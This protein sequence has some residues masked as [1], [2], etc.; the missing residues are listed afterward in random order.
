VLYDGDAAGIKAALRGIDLL[1]ED[2]MNVKVLLL[3]DGEDPDSFARSHNATEFAEYIEKYETD[4]IRFKTKL[5]LGETKDPFK[6]AEVISDII[7]TISLIPDRIIR[8]VYVQECASMMNIDVAILN[9]EVNTKISRRANSNIGYVSPVGHTAPPRPSASASTQTQSQPMD[10]ETPPP[11]PPM[12]EDYPV[13]PTQED[14][15][16]SSMPDNV[17]PPPPP[18]PEDEEAMGIPPAPSQ[19]IVNKEV[20][21]AKAVFEKSEVP[22]IRY[23]VRYGEKILFEAD[24]ETGEPAISVVE[25]IHD[26]IARDDLQMQT[27]IFKQILDECYAKI[28]EEEGFVASKYLLY[29][30]DS[31]IRKIAV[32][33][34]ADKYQLSKYHSKFQKIETEEEQLPV[35]VPKDLYAFKEAYVMREIKRVQTEI[36]QC[37]NDEDFEKILSLMSELSVW[38]NLKMVLCKELGERIVLKM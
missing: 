30:E 25:Y 3:P 28:K 38:N 7:R 21:R 19:E 27:P 34:L 17:P 20:N 33:L 35:T 12:P 6:R 4:F 10:A 8:T 32:N 1:I 31:T 23:I 29:H 2:G 9:K 36:S 5:L 16:A 14:Y 13:P 24:E 26:D 37:N 18:L 11:P 22:L 15:P